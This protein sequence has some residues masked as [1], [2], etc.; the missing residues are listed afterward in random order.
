MSVLGAFGVA[1]LLVVTPAESP[2]ADAAK[3]GDIAELRSLL[4]DGADVNAAQGDGMTALHWAAT[5]N[6]VA[7][8]SVL[9]YAGANLESTTR[10]GA[11]TSLHLASKAGNAPVMEMLLKSGSDANATRECPLQKMSVLI[12]TSSKSPVDG[13]YSMAR[14][15]SPTAG[16]E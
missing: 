11:Y 7:M 12:E 13:S 5:H 3:R 4:K 16:Y 2:V 10:L 14:D 8:A 1:A 6:D 15:P 9:I